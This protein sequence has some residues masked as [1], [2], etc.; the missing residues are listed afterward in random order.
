[1]M[2]FIDTTGIRWLRRP[3][4]STAT[5]TPSLNEA[6]LGLNFET[7]KKRETTYLLFK[8]HKK[9]RGFLLKLLFMESKNIVILLK[10]V[11]FSE[12]ISKLMCI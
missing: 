9:M 12:T 5:E 11:Y 2:A 4:S 6:T 8:Y 1:M 10:D 7:P 3:S